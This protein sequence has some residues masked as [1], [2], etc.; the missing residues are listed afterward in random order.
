MAGARKDSPPSAIQGS[1]PWLPTTWVISS[2]T[3]ASALQAEGGWRKASMIH[4]SSRSEAKWT[5]PSVR[6]EAT[7][8]GVLAQLVERDNGIVEAQGSTP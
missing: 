4:Q 5:S 6:E 3:R 8:Y 7:F 1:I 2:F